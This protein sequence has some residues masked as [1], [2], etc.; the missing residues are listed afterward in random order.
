MPLDIIVDDE[1]YPMWPQ[2]EIT[3]VADDIRVFSNW[4]KSNWQMRHTD[5]R[6]LENGTIVVN[7]KC[8]GVFLCTSA[9]C[10]YVGRPQIIAS[11]RESTIGK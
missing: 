2:G 9:N 3:L 5:K 8:V 1:G 6:Q 10:A 7:K 11:A 4:G